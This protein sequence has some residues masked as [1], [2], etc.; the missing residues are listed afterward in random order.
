M[1][2]TEWVLRSVYKFSPAQFA[3]F[4]EWMPADGEM[5][6]TFFDKALRKKAGKLGL[7]AEA[8]A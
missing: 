5:F 2:E 3:D 8:V 7:N 6:L 1:Q 4:V